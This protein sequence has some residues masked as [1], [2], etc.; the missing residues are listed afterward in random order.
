MYP[1]DAPQER[2]LRA[3]SLLGLETVR[4]REHLMLR[5]VYRGRM[6][7][8]TLPNHP[9]IKSGTLRGACRHDLG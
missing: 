8:L 4:R 6:V 7:T 5:G 2:V 3:F 1:A 9:R